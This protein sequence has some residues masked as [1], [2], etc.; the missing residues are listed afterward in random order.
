MPWI[1]KLRRESMAITD[2]T[3]KILW[4]RS[5]NCCAIC[6]QSLVIEATPFDVE[7]IV[8][9]ECHI[10]S[11]QENGPRNDPTYP[12]KLIDSYD[13][14]IL[15]CSVHHKMID[16]QWETY[17]IDLLRQIKAN[18]EKWVHEKLKDK[19]K[20]ITIKRIRENV[21]EYLPKV[22]TGKELFNI[23]NG[24]HA[25]AFDNDE[26][27]TE[28]EVELV[29]SFFQVLQDWG[30]ISSD[31]EAYDKVR[32]E[33][34]LTNEL[35]KLEEAGFFVFG[36]TEIQELHG[37]T[38]PPSNWKLAIVKVLRITNESILKLNFE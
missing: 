29:G 11:G 23:I 20:K 32:V 14:L 25:Y 17:T 38:T 34:E 18:H 19:P 35:K 16:D 4:A 21:P 3:R 30:D 13:N 28:E 10:I 26:L 8:G 37:G 7:S 22:E 9:E 1:F 33:F 36:G 6:R 27:N 15:L 31:L 24:A 2:K 12:K 5:G